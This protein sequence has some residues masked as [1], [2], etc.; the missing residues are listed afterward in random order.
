MTKRTLLIALTL[1]AAVIPAAPAA[2][3]TSG[4]AYFKVSFKATQ[5][6]SWKELTT[7]Q[8]KCAGTIEI[9]GSGSSAIRLASS[10][11][12]ALMIRRVAGANAASLTFA[13]GS[14]SLPVS[15]TYSRAGFRTAR[16]LS[17]VPPGRCPRQEDPPPPDCGT[18]RYPAGTTVSLAYETVEMQ[19]PDDLVGSL[20]DGVVTSGPQTPGWTAAAPYL[21]CPSGTTLDHHLGILRPFN[22]G[23]YL[24]PDTGKAALPIAKVFGKRKRFRVRYSDKATIDETPPGQGTRPVTTQLRWVVTFTRLAHRPAGF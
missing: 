12:R 14:Q 4:V 1:A 16:S 21:N 7:Y 10:R 11:P 6:M 18:K 2:A 3:R 19:D 15:G 23:P 22:G 17:A 5:Q 13:D 9:S 20:V 8:S 24:S